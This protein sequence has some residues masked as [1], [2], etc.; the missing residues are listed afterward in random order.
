MHG[1][2]GNDIPL[3]YL[4]QILTC[5]K[6]SRASTAQLWGCPS[7]S[8]FLSRLL[9]SGIAHFFARPA[10]ENGS[11]RGGGTAHLAR[12]ERKTSVFSRND[13]P[14]DLGR[15]T[16]LTGS[17][18]I[19]TAL[20]AASYKSQHFVPACA[21]GAEGIPLSW[22]STFSFRRRV[23]ADRPPSLPRMA[24]PPRGLHFCPSAR[25]NIAPG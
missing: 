22:K 6:R 24:S 12:T 25:Q 11:I 9:S 10:L 7:F 18:L 23:P 20:D 3:L 15:K 13:R 1:G 5:R 14:S 16:F 19:S 2:F 17:A 8:L 21:A 4:F